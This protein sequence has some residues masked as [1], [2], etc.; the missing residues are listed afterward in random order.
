M[1]S[2]KR[3]LT[4]NWDCYNNVHCWRRE[5][6]IYERCSLIEISLYQLARADGDR[7]V[8]KNDFQRDFDIEW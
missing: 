2:P 3:G 7:V 1:Y 8:E 6:F 5:M 4:S